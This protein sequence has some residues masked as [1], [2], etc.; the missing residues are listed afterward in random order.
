MNCNSVLRF[1][2]YTPFPP[3]VGE[4]PCRGLLSIESIQTQGRPE[5]VASDI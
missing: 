1:C 2:D 3:K 4:K 5:H